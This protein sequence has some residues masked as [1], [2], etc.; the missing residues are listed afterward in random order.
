MMAIDTKPALA[1]PGAPVLLAAF[2]REDEEGDVRVQQYDDSNFRVG[3]FLPGVVI[4]LP[5]DTAKVEPEISQW[6]KTLSEA[7]EVF[8][9]YV[10]QARQAGWLRTELSPD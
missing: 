10:Q 5:G 8:D 9:R 3:T 7:R 4:D 1:Y 2:R 6:V